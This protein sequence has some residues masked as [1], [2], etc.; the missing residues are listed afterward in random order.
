MNQSLMQRFVE[1]AFDQAKT[2]DLETIHTFQ[3]SGEEI[4]GLKTDLECLASEGR[5][6][7]ELR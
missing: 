2:A 7:L 6:D 1:W 5:E 4:N 3:C